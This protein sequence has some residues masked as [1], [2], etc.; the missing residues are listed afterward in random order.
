MDVPR[1]LIADDDADFK[2]ILSSKL[3]AAGYEI[4]E[5]KEGAEAVVKAKILHPHLV[6][7][8]IQMPG[9][10]GTEAVLEIKGDPETK[11]MKI[12][13]FSNLTY[14]WPAA[15]TDNPEFAKGLGAVTFLSKSDDMD[16][17]VAKVKELV[18]I[19]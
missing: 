5:A 12:I 3:L 6:I 4:A 14:P 10:N 15:R 11:D 13:F 18:P 8:D 1:I 16:N 17:V 9:V 19:G 2:E 7:M